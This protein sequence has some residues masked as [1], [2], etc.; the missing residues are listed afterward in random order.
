MKKFLILI[1]LILGMG[2]VM[3][4]NAGTKN[5]T[6]ITGATTTDSIRITQDLTPVALYSDSMHVKT[7]ATFQASFG[8]ALTRTWYTVAA[9]GD[10]TAYTVPLPRNTNVLIPL[11][12][13]TFTGLVGRATNEAIWLR[14]KLADAQTLNKVFKL[15]MK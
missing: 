11:T 5:L 12:T 10:T 15:I 9:I 14:I 8:N 6:L 4:Q 13:G 2:S 7:S 3:A 1:T